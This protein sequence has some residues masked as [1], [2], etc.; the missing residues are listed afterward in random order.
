MKYEK[1]ES[2]WGGIILLIVVMLF[3]WLF[4]EPNSYSSQ[5]RECFDTGRGLICE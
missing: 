2:Y 1:K 5:D 4:I 3:T